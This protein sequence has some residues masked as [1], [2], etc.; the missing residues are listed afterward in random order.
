[1]YTRLAALL[2]L[3]PTVALAQGFVEDHGAFAWRQGDKEIRFANGVWQAGLPGGKMIRFHTFLWHDAWLYET[4]QGGKAEQG[5]TLEA[6]GSLTMNGV[7]SARED[8]AP[9]RYWLKATPSAEGVKVHLEFEKSTPLK[10]TS[11]VWLHVF[12]ERNTFAGTERV[13]ADPAGHGRLTSPSLGACERLL[14]ELQDGLSLCL[15][16]DGFHEVTS[17]G[18]KSAYVMRMNLVAGDFEEG[19][20]VSGDLNITFAQMPASFPGEIKPSQ[21]PLAIRKV[22][23]NL[24]AVP[25]FDKLELAVDL[26]ATYD[27]PFDP[28]DV[29]LDADFT[30]P[31]GKR[32]IVPGFFAVQM[33]RE[34]R[35]GNE[36]MV[37]EGNGAWRVRFAPNEVGDWKWTLCL[38]D[39]T[40]QINGGT[41]SFR[42][43]AGPS[44]GFLR[45]SKAD[46]HYLAFDDGA[47][48][49]AIGHNLPGYHSS[50]QLAEEAMR[51]F[52]A[53]GENFNRWWLYSYNLGIEW[54]DR[55]GWYKQDAAA[56]MDQA[57]EWGRELGLYYMMC[58]DTHQDFRT[59]GWDRNPFNV[60]NGGPCEKA[61]E[62]FTN[63][64]AR[65]YYKKR[66]RYEVARWGYS[67]SV[68]C[69]EF[70]NEIE[71]W[72]DSTDEIKLPWTREM[73]DTLND[74]DPYRHLITTSFW[75]HTGPPA[76]WALPNIDIVQTHLYTNNDGN[77][78]DPV[79]AMSLK[80][81]R[82]FPKPHIFGEFGIRSHASTVDKDPPGWGL[83]NALWAGL[84]SF[85][86]GGP[87]P[88]W[89]EN[90]IDPLDLYFHFTA[91][92]NFSKGLP[93]GTAKWEPLE[94]SVAFQDKNRPPETADATVIPVSRWGKPDDVEF[95]LQED[96]NLADGKRPQ[97][98]LQGLGHKD[99]A[100]PVTFNVSYPK[101]GQFVMHIGRVSNSGLVRVWVDGQQVK[102]LDLPCGDGLGK[103]SKWQE[104]WK[105]WESVYDQDY[106]FDIPAGQHQIK[107]EN[108]GK[109][110]VSVDRYTFAG[111][112]VRRTPNVLAGGMQTQGLAVLWLQNRDSDWYNHAQNRVPPVDAVTTTLTGLPDGQYAMETWE[113]WK[114]TLTKTDTM[115]VRQGKLELRLPELKTDVALKIRK[116]GP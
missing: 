88:W 46:P 52:A 68:L 112:Q 33:R 16:P 74:I 104:Q 29:A 105:L 5:P 76:Y 25:R 95:T 94:A 115:T 87:M 106:A 49:F 101:A 66:L 79:R 100:T 40:G 24:T 67:P 7:F 57:L 107:V 91:I 26:G 75:S 23:P 62:F 9:L 19:K 31:S 56:R 10:L 65:A 110:W 97:Q 71:G 72:A 81:W 42:C 69:W 37:P 61:G 89:H 35:A 11:G 20:R 114:G 47:G 55:L 103:S 51:K 21:Q 18:N 45:V 93:L 70:G 41:G 53:A 96:G 13:W 92:A 63:E 59:T 111:C 39:R 64:Q 1:M 14:V 116:V 36:I 80:Q 78:A 34:I 86:A 43:V 99:I 8:S 48:F 12:A 109:D 113:T 27:N 30:S 82:E 15:A 50:R 54:T 60:K 84:T 77:V 44:H 6:D 17:E 83:H 58:L 102:E 90:Y 98:L 22:T 108:S 73:S 38:K 85:C 2:L 3:A 32:F 28:D 4:L